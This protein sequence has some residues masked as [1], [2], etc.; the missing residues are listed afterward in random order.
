MAC[1]CGGGLVERVANGT[2]GKNGVI[3]RNKETGE[4][5]DFSTV[6][7][8]V[9][10]FDGTE[11]VADTLIDPGAVIFLGA[12]VQPGEIIFEL[13]SLGVPALEDPRAATLLAFDNTSGLPQAIVCLDDDELLFNFSDC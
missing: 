12:T 1:E 5:L 4:V 9:L 13:G 11:I 3:F 8:M 2:R 7:R 10:S 6:T